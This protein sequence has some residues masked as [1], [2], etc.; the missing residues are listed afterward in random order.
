MVSRLAAALAHLLKHAERFRA[1]NMRR[2]SSHLA[3]RGAKRCRRALARSPERMRR[4]RKVPTGRVL[5]CGDAWEKW[6]HICVSSSSARYRTPSALTHKHTHSHTKR[7]TEAQPK[8]ALKRPKTERIR[9]QRRNRLPRLGC[10]R[11]L[12][13]P[14]PSFEPDLTLQIPERK[15]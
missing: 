11:E 8:S 3:S 13:R 14:N 1:E 15:N 7:G 2:L 10:R 6:R 9:N 12:V 4:H 5:S